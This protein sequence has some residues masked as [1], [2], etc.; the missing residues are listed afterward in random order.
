MS[1]DRSMAEIIDGLSDPDRLVRTSA[2][3]NVMDWGESGR[4]ALPALKKLLDDQR[5]PYIRLGAAGAICRI[6]PDEAEGVLPVLLA[7]LHDN[8]FMQRDTACMF[9]GRIGPKAEAAVPT[10]RLLLDDE[11]ETVRCSAADAIGRISG[12]WSHA[13]EIG[14]TLI[15]SSDFL[16][17]IVG[18]EH[19][20]AMG[21]EAKAA[22]PRLRGLLRCVEWQARVDVEEVLDEINRC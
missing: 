4:P 22:M 9:I 6:A 2:V 5:E 18:A 16:I 13:I 12:D 7:D 11:I 17:R 20:E 3:W 1:D 21:T 19:F 14:L 15:Q 8:D 10:L